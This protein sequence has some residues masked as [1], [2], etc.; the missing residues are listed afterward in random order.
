MKIETLVKYQKNEV[1]RKKAYL[2]KLVDT[3]KIDQDLADLEIEKA[4]AVF[5]VLTQIKGLQG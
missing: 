1:S 3:G 5:R 2:Q 4:S